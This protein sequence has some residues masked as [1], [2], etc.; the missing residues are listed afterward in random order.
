MEEINLNIHIREEIGRRK[1][2]GIR[3]EDFV[4]GVV[5]GGEDKKSTIIKV[6]R[7]AYEG[8]MRQQRGQNVI[9][10]LNV[11]DGD[12]KLRDYSAII[13]EEQHEPVSF[14]L[15]HLDFQRIS[16]TEEIEVK[17]PVEISGQAI[18]V[19]QDGGSLDQP[20]WE[21]S[22]VCLPTNI[23]E[24]IVVDVTLLKI[25]D[26]IHVKDIVLPPQVK[27]KHD[28]GTLVVTVVPPMKEEVEVAPTEVLTEPEV[29]REKKEEKG[30]VKEKEEGKEK[31]KPTKEKSQEASGEKK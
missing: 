18:G 14:K 21:M 7:R 5:Y 26:A 28:P 16:L 12:K 24:K 29:I 22:V 11:M 25:G 31:E 13:R 20:L 27:T 10:R 1:L 9:F 30:A 8:L 19:T 4:P 23:P 15:L 2:R 3:R 17:V 6:P